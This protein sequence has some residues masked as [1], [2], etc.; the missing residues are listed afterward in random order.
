MRNESR[1][2]I[3]SFYIKSIRVESTSIVIGLTTFL[4]I[5]PFLWHLLYLEQIGF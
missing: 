2:S 1:S 4:T 3:E 5:H